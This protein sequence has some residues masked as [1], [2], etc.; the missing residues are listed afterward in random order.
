MAEGEDILGYTPVGTDREPV[1]TVPGA[2]DGIHVQG[3]V[4]PIYMT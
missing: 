2:G 1:A 3:K 4:V